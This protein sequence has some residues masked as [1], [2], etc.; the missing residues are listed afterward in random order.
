MTI[1]SE[2]YANDPCHA[3]ET[4]A[5]HD[6]KMREHERLGFTLEEYQRRY[7]HVLANMKS[8]GVDVL[9]IR[10]PENICYLTG[11]ETP[12]FYGYHCLLVS[13]RE[14]PVL[15]VRRIEEINAPE[16]SWLTR[17]VPV[18]DYQYP[19]EF[20]I[21]E[22]KKIGAG[23]SCIGVEKGMGHDRRCHEKRGMLFTVAEYE[24]LTAGLPDATFIDSK[25]I[26]ED[27]RV[28][29]SDAEVEMMRRAAR[30][31]D[32]ALLAGIEATK[33]GATEDEIAA[34]IYYEWCK[35]GAEYTGLPNFVT[36]GPRHA[37]NHATWRG[38][39]I[40]AGDP[41]FF[42]IAA[43]KFR[44]CG[45]ILR[46]AIVG[47]PSKR[48]RELE[49]ATR[50]AFELAVD[51]MRPGVSCEAVDRACHDL[52]ARYRFGSTHFH[53]SAYSLGLNFPPDWGEGHIL[54]VQPGEKRLL[55]RNMTFHLLP[56]CI[57]PGDISIQFSGTVRITDNGCEI[58]NEVPVELFV[59]E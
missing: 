4:R 1:I 24:A 33:V 13:A 45:A 37:I 56:A 10:S 59:V 3:I 42:E 39:T 58:L 50:D 36:S 30:I 19:F 54:S 32:K 7:D 53:R 40:E 20:V 25:G 51:I 34:A 55:E 46:C 2:R 38:R 47:E 18:D 35:N 49:K 8:A 57:A 15:V 27:A 52:F 14:E 48:V 41:I 22:L 21:E 5:G 17:T 6:L 16:F 43:S 9:V 29:K 31:A 23:H 11:Y 28:V 12:G 44:Y 26:V